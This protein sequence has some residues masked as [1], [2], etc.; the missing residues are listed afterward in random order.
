MRGVGYERH[1]A[2]DPGQSGHLKE[3]GNMEERG[4]TANHVRR[5]AE[6]WIGTG[7]GS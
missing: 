4:I 3:G 1:G 2:N 6:D 5:R 7:L